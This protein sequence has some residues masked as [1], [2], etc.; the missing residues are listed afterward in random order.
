MGKNKVNIILGFDLAALSASSQNAIRGLKKTSRKMQSIGKTMALGIS[1]PIIAL[2]GLAA[3]EFADFE[4]SMAKV[5]AIS[6][7]TSTQLEKLTGISKE[8]GLTTRFTASE[9]SN[10]QLNYAKL[11][12]VPK[13]IGKITGAT[14]DLALATG[15]DLA[16]S[17]EVAGQ[18]LRAFGFGANQ[19]QRIVDVIASSISNSALTLEKFSAAMGR[20]API[21]SVTGV[22][23]E[24]LVA[25]QSVLINSGIEASTVSTGL[26]KIFTDLSKS[27]LT[28]EEAMDKI[29]NSTNKTKTAFNLFGQRALT[30]AIILADN[31]K[32]IKGLTST[33]LESAGAAKTM[34]GIMDDTLTG[35][36]FRLKSAAQALG[37]SFGEVLGPV[38]RDIAG[39]MAKFARTI[40]GASDNTKK[41]ILVI[42]AVVAGIGPLIFAIGL[43]TAAFAFLAANPIVLA[44]TIIILKLALLVATFIFVRDNAKA[45]AD[46]FSNIWVQVKNAAI[47]AVQGILA[48]LNKLLAFFGIDISGALIEKLESLKG[49]VNENTKAFGSFGKAIK[50]AM[51]LAR[52]DMDATT[53]SVEDLGSALGKIKA[54]DFSGE[55]QGLNSKSLDTIKPLEAPVTIKIDKIELTSELKKGLNVA[56]D[57]LL[58]FTEKLNSMIQDTI[59]GLVDSIAQGISDIVAGTFDPKTFGLQLLQTVG[60]FMVTLGKQMLIFGGLF[61]LFQTA[62]A[63]LH[64]EVAIAAG[65]AMIAAG[66]VIKG[67]AA[68]GLQGAS[69]SGSGS[70][71]GGGGNRNLVFSKIGA[72]DFTLKTEL[73]GSNLSLALNRNTSFRR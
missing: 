11:G 31:Q 72:E 71:G 69:A 8:L 24:R 19:M 67:I 64:P 7:A 56:R 73:S 62:I 49:T 4:Q 25:M 13:E 51:G 10:L 17:A 54:L 36:L 70:S 44:I 2:G 16:D 33:Y 28:F 55:V 30:T 66:A 26:R 14:L 57:K 29:R 59:L 53:D 3:K 21:A 20:V 12:F 27:G 18:T 32:Q 9:V 61:K 58:A 37:I 50:K 45:F 63:S 15:E 65:I 34:A 5:K 42:A 1:L 35:S 41:I 22:S 43:L 23:L 40:E 46:R 6:G 39:K 60:Q 48:S 68:K 47:T 38:I 52:E